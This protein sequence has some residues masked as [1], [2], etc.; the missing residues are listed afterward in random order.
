M[1]KLRDFFVGLPAACG[2]KNADKWGAVN[3]LQFDFEVANPSSVFDGTGQTINE[4]LE[5]AFGWAGRDLSKF[6]VETYAK[7]LAA[8]LALASAVNAKGRDDLLDE[9]NLLASTLRLAEPQFPTV[10]ALMTV[11]QAVVQGNWA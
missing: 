4:R 11:D 3:G 2:A 6:D 1:S 10:S 7:N 8:L 5:T 9:A